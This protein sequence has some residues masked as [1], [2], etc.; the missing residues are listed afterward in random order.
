MT[1]HQLANELR[2]RQYKHGEVEKHIIDRLSDDDIIDCY[3]T[4]NCCNKK[5]VNPKQLEIAIQT[6][7]NSEDFFEI[8]D[9]MAPKGH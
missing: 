3:I 7:E 1:K 8:C 5:Q 6:S 2:E 9:R 4:C